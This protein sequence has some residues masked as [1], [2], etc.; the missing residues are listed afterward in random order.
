[1]IDLKTKFIRATKKSDFVS[2]LSP[3]G[4]DSS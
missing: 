2:I 3:M 1:M 4:R